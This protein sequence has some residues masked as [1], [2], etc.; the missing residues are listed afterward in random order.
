MPEPWEKPC[1]ECEGDGLMWP[2]VEDIACDV[3]HGTG[4]VPMNTDE[5]LE[6][7]LSAV[8]HVGF[9][10]VPGGVMLLHSLDVDGGDGENFTGPT[11]A[12]ALRAA[13]MAVADA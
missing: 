13:L 12:D 8:G 3:C 9:S 4:Y 7:L 6:A 2:G 1:P 11:P 5:L 10:L